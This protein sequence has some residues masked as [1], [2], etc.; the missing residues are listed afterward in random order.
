MGLKGLSFN[1]SSTLV[2][3]VT[4]WDWVFFLKD[5]ETRKEIRKVCLRIAK[6]IGNPIYVPDSYC[7]SSYLFEGK[8]YS[9]VISSLRAKHGEPVI[10]ISDMLVQNEMS[11]DTAG[12][13]IDSIK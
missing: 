7:Y 6:H 11:W 12:Y 4:E 3:L 1:I 5:L 8:T 13:F 9:D 2:E 10:D